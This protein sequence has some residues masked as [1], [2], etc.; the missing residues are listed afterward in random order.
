MTANVGFIILKGFSYELSVWAETYT[1]RIF[2]I[3]LSDYLI[4][5]MMVPL[6]VYTLIDK[7]NSFD[8]TGN[9]W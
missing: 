5:Y 1:S 4:I 9:R 7:P 6:T 8:S 3:L 2:S